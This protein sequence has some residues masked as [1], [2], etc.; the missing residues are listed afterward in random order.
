MTSSEVC[1]EPGLER[2][3]GMNDDFGPWDD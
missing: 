1:V 3:V 2:N